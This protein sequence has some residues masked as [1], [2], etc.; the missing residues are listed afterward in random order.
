MV[1][2]NPL[3]NKKKKVVQINII[4]IYIKEKHTAKITA[5]NS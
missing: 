4:Y 1:S 3:D 2:K 5:K